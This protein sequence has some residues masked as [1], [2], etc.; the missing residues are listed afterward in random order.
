MTKVSAPRFGLDDCNDD[1]ERQFIEALHA[2]AEVAGWFADGWPRDD[3]III[4]VCPVDAEYNS[5]LRTLRVDFDGHSV[6]FGTDETHQLVTDL[7]PS[8]PGVELLRARP[9]QDLASAAA[10]WLEREMKRPIVRHEWNRKDFTRRLWVLAD[11]QEGL[12]VSDSSNATTRDSIGPPDRSVTLPGG[13]DW[14]P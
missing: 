10:D 2:R 6:V 4:T 14:K 13:F 7:D 11:T 12:V 9:I 1:S 8:R 5:V 3:R